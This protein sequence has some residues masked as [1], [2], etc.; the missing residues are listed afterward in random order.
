VRAR[1][2]R[3]VAGIERILFGIVDQA[4]DRDWAVGPKETVVGGGGD[5]MTTPRTS[6]RHAA[7]DLEGDQLAGEDA[8]VEKIDIEVLAD[9][10][11][12]VDLLDMHS[13]VLEDRAR[14]SDRG[15][16]GLSPRPRT[17]SASDPVLIAIRRHDKPIVGEWTDMSARKTRL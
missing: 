16:L 6:V 8:L 13:G 4:E 2:R 1:P 17:F 5:L 10:V 7:L 12:G 3:E 14:R 11:G 9:V 15:A